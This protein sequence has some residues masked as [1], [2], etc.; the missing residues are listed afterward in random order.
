LVA[1]VLV[2]LIATLRAPTLVAQDAAPARQQPYPKV[3]PPGEGA[4]LVNTNCTLC[5]STML[6][7]QQRKDS[8]GWEKSVQLMER[9]GARLVPDD[10]AKV[11]AYLITNFGP[12]KK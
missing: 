2:G 12:P 9:W 11:V 3:L 8:T 6:I 10:H 5:H 4:D 7:T 1:G